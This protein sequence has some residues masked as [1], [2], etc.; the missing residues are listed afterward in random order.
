MNESKSINLPIFVKLYRILLS[1]WVVLFP[2]SYARRYF[3]IACN[4]ELNLRDPKDYNEKVQWLKV[5]SDLTQWT[6]LADKYKVRRYL[7]EHHLGHI[8]PD[9]YG[10]WKNPHDINF[11][12][13][14]V[15]FVLKSTSGS[16]NNLLVYNKNDLDIKATRELLSRWVNEKEGLV[17]FQPHYWNIKPRIIAEELLVD[18]ATNDV[19]ASLVD[20]K[21]FCF[22]GE[23]FIINVIWDRSNSVVGST[24]RPKDKA[25]RENVY[26]IHWNI[27]ENAYSPFFPRDELSHLPK[28][29]CFEEMITVCRIL[30]KPFP[31]VRIDL[32]EVN[33]HI[34]FGE[35]TFTPG[36]LTVFSSDLYEQMGDRIDLSLAA[37]RKKLLI[38]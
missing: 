2:G 12:S 33:N 18:T 35:F 17:S 29:K 7:E 4:K 8:L 20:Y 15:R 37:R 24:I 32:Y 28:P 6:E 3:R 38:I 26:D 34:Y 1:L 5:Y 27:V 13:L 30:S 14:P 25:F 10:V 19:S 16:G 22:H 31:Q 21:F 11:D 36:E 9:L 23:P